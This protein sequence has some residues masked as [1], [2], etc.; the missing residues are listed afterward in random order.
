[1]ARVFPNLD[2]FTMESL[3]EVTSSVDLT[4]QWCRENGLLASDLDCFGGNCLGGANPMSL[5]RRMRGDGE[6]WRC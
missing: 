3:F 4:I 1:M 2:D 5:R 6:I